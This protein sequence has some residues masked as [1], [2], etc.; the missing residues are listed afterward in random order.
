[1][2]KHRDLATLLRSSSS[3][4]GTVESAMVPREHWKEYAGEDDGTF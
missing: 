4:Q 3:D 1:M 2:L